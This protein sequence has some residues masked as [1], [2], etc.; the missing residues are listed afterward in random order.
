MFGPSDVRYFRYSLEKAADLRLVCQE[1]ADDI[2]VSPEDDPDV[3]RAVGD[4]QADVGRVSGRKP[5]LRETL[6]PGG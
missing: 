3:I 4:L 1:A 5:R 6:D 2:Y